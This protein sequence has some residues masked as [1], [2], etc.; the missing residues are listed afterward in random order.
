MTRV[1]ALA[2]CIY[3]IGLS[4]GQVLFKR[5]ANSLSDGLG[6][7]AFQQLA[8]SPPFL[9]AVVLYGG[10]TVYWTYL[11]ARVPLALAYPFVA[12]CFV[13]VPMFSAALFD[14]RISGAYYGGIVCIVIGVLIIAVWGS[15]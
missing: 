2:L 13:L 15:K 7:L 12:L 14:E 9:L 10:L 4:V 3:S 1:D 6:G 8:F 5:A 11:L